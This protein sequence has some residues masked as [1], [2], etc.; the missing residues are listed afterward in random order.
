MLFQFLLRQITFDEPLEVVLDGRSQ[1]GVV[2]KPG[3]SFAVYVAQVDHYMDLMQ[4]QD[5]SM[6]YG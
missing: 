6:T 5:G 2:M 4:Q 1:R 3:K